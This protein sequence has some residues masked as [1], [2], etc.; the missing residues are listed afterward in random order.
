MLLSNSVLQIISVSIAYGHVTSTE[1]QPESLSCLLWCG[2]GNSQVVYAPA[3]AAERVKNVGH[4]LSI[5]ANGPFQKL[6]VPTHA[7]ILT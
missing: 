5:T 4:F 7:Y 6:M 2:Y 3:D 1:V